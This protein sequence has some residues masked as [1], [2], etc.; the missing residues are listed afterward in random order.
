MRSFIISFLLFVLASFI[1]NDQHCSLTIKVTNF[2]SVKGV[3]EIGLYR[4]PSSF[5]KVGQTHRMVR[6]KV[7]SSEETYTFTNLS[8]DKYA[9]CVYHD[10][11]SN[12]VCDKN[13]IGIPT[14]GFGFSNNIRPRWSAPD[15]D[16]CAIHLINQKTFRIQLI[17]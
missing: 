8:S 6:V 13:V 9:V 17:N 1:P 4:D 14:E 16:E 12:K 10:E 3:L 11:N 15:F 5:P 7:E 2:R